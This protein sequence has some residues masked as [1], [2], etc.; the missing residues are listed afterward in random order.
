MEEGEKGSG[1]RERGREGE[2]ER[3][4]VYTYIC[5]YRQE[6]GEWGRERR[7]KGQRGWGRERKGVGKKEGERGGGGNIA[8]AWG[9]QNHSTSEE[10]G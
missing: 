1:E 4:C 10:K 2:I 8:Q 7:G 6:R 5:K 3:M 9:L